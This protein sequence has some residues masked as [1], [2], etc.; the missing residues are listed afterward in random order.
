MTLLIFLLLL[1]FLVVIHELGHFLAARRSGVKVEEFGI[2]YPPK[3][4]R[5]FTDKRGTEYTLNWLPFGGFVRLYG[6]DGKET[7]DAGVAFYSKSKPVRLMII[8]AGAVINF[9]FGVLAFGAIYTYTGIPTEMELVRIDEV[10]VGSPAEEAG[11]Q[12]G[13]EVVAVAADNE[14]VEVKTVGEFVEEVGYYRGE[15]VRLVLTDERVVPVYVRTVE[16]TPDDQGALGV[17]VSDFEFRHYPLW[18]MP[19]RG[20]WVG[21]QAAVAFGILL[22]VSLGEMLRNLIFSGVVPTEVA[23][24]VGIVHTAAKEGLLTSGWVTIVNFAAILSINLAIVNMLPIPALDGGRALFIFLEGFIGK[25]RMPK[26]ERYA[27]TAGMAMLLFLIL[28]ISIR[29][30]RGVLADEWVKTWWQGVLGGF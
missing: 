22:L 28:A 27:N 29:D 5:L 7:K 13:E 18:Q 15:E 8:V 17:L 10:M 3:A 19:F 20:M 14:V 12:G 6:E 16:E 1:S 4:K 11:L 30:V 9:L 21:L 23:G 26:V 25:S 2:G 24:P